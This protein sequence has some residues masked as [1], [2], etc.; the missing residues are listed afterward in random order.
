MFQKELMPLYNRLNSQNNNFR[1]HK[2]TLK[3]NGLVG[4]SKL[5]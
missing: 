3:F 2:N 1:K 5:A 4:W